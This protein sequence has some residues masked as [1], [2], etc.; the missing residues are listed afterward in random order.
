MGNVLVSSETLTQD[1]ELGTSPTDIEQD[2]KK[3]LSRYYERGF[4][5]A[6]ITQ[7]RLELLPDFKSVD[8]IFHV[9]EGELCRLYSLVFT[10]DLPSGQ[11]SIELRKKISFQDHDVINLIKLQEEVDMLLNPLREEGYGFAHMKPHL[12]WV[13]DEIA[14]EYEIIKENPVLIH[15]VE[16]DENHQKASPL[17]KRELSKLQNKPYRHSQLQTARD[18]LLALGYLSEVDFSLSKTKNPGEADLLVRVTQSQ[19]WQFSLSPMFVGNE[20]LILTGFLSHRNFLNLGLTTSAS[21]QVSKWRQ[22]FELSLWDPGLFSSINSSFFEIHH[23]QFQYVSFSQSRT[24]ASSIFTFPTLLFLKLGI[25]VSMDQVS[26]SEQI[27]MPKDNLRN[28]LSLFGIWDFSHT[29]LPHRYGL[30]IRNDVTYAGPLTFSSSSFD[31]IN[32]RNRLK[33]WVLNGKNIQISSRTETASLFPIGTKQAPLSERYFLG[34]QG[35]IRGYLPR[36]IG[37]FLDHF[38]I[39]GIFSFIQSLELEFSFSKW[40]PFR[41]YIFIDAGN[42]FLNARDFISHPTLFASTGFGFLFSFLG[43]PLK[44]ELGIPLAKAPV[45]VP[46][47]LYFGFAPSTHPLP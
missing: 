10:G 42:S 31:F 1:L 20:G 8:V 29:H 14:I 5:Q 32:L 7:T 36:S 27:F 4:L 15:N 47:D 30:Q 33:M 26:L 35:S 39:G 23:R 45:S 41:N 28:A 12:R 6:K 44:V 40:I 2:K 17:A 43:F 46:F 24:G 13:E 16:I 19:P 21:M 25:G 37:P 11:S 22:L 3:L 18:H 9:D 38:Q 34:G